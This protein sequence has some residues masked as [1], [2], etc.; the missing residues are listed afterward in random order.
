MNANKEV[1]GNEVATKEAHEGP[2]NDDIVVIWRGT[3]I[4]QEDEAT[5]WK[6]VEDHFLPQHGEEHA[7]VAI[8]DVS[9]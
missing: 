1:G 5:T 9:L 7:S 6:L 2:A 3:T 8:L 4:S